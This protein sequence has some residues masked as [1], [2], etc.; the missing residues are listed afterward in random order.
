MRRAIPFLLVLLLTDPDASAQDAPPAAQAPLGDL[1][2]TIECI[3]RLESQRD[4]KCYATASRLEDFMYGT[5]L[6]EEARFAKIAL[7]KGLIQSVWGL[8]DARGRAAGVPMLS[9]AELEPVLDQILPR[10]KSANDDWLLDTPS[11]EKLTI[12]AR[13]KRQYATVAYGLRAILAVQQ[14]RFLMQGA[15]LLS[16]D[17]EATE[18]LKE[19]L[20]VYSLAALQ[21]ADQ[22]ARL[23]DER[24]IDA[25]RLTSAWEAI[26][27]L[28]RPPATDAV[29]PEQRTAPRSAAPYALTRRVAAQKIASYQAYNDI[30]MPVFL[31]NIQVYFARHRWASDPEQSTRL[32]TMFTETLIAFAG[33]LLLGAEKVAAAQNR[34]LI[35]IDDVSRFAR[36][37]I[38]HELNEY[39][40]AIFFPNL[41][42]DQRITV[43]AYDMDAFRDS[44]LHWQYLSAAIDE[45]GFRGTLEPDPFA[46][47][48]LVENIAQFGVLALRV[49]GDIATEEGVEELAPRHLEQALRRIQERIIAHGQQPARAAEP[50]A[51]A[52]SSESLAADPAHAF[53]TDVTSKAGLDFEHRSS[54]WLNRFIR[55]YSVRNKN[56]AVLAVPPAF[57]GSGAAAE[58][59][60]GDG[61]PDL[62][63]L[64]GSGNHLYLNDG[65]GGLRDATEDSGIAWTRDDGLP[66]EPRQPIIADFDNDG[67]QDILITY[68]D[69]PHRLYKGLGDGRFKDVTGDAGLGGKGLVGGPATAIDFDKDGLLDLYITYFGQYLEGVLPTLA[70]RNDNGLPNRLFR[71]TGGM[72]FKDVTEGSGVAGSGWTQAVAHT[73]FDLDGWQDLIEGNDFGVNAYYRNRGDGTFEN[74][75]GRLG[76]GKPS[77][78]MG[79]GIADLNGDLHPDMYISNIVTMDKDQ[80]YVNPGSDTPMKFD[81]ATMAEMRVVEANDLFVSRPATEDGLEY[82]QS[83][84]V[85]RGRSSTGWAWGADFFDFDNDGDDDLYVANGMNEFAVYSSENPYYKDPEGKERNVYFPQ[86]TRETNVFFANEGGKLLNMSDKS[87]AGLL[88]NSRAVVYLDLDQDGDLDM[89]LNNLHEPAVAYRN[90]AEGLNR[91]WIKVRLIGDP[92]QQTTRDAIGA[93]L[94]ATTAAKQT[95][96]REVHGSGA[97]LTMHPKTQHIGLG[98]SETANLAVHWPGGKIDRFS[99]L[100]ADRVYVVHQKDGSLTEQN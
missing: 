66:G 27:R 14:E 99:G 19:F 32:K 53:F 33:D 22:K 55:S 62:L 95:V 28:P 74:V 4:P 36:A 56:V 40:D 67:F 21:T 49:A 26:G 43:E 69:D 29:P 59:V 75:A 18:M 57:Q 88:G 54:D 48:L 42:R 7:Q 30:A 89:V 2:T 68:V 23:A 3:G 60:N 64:S 94:V 6:S 92:K 8:A 11:G 44:G 45:P 35:R 16:L 37:F 52:S 13:D 12:A 61:F 58:D 82:A 70:R 51:L 86:S 91:H 25:T 34:E 63:L 90:N 46:L 10:G 73:D 38:P 31:R 76:T 5:P 1:A 100:K 39:E 15:S 50:V 41:P 80:K 71:N 72:R 20:D 96:W 97:Y 93:T 79:I 81:A 98:Q 47:E 87:G 9:P 65:K 84:A 83:T 17:T 77:F 85:A 78:T 24:E